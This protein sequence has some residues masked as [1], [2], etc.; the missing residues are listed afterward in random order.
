[1]RMYIYI[2]I[3]TLRHLNMHE[4][5]GTVFMAASPRLNAQGILFGSL[6]KGG[7]WGRGKPAAGI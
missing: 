1:M 5:W 3:Y 7:V 6:F 2:Y 4:F